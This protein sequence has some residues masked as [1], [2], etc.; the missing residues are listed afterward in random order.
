MLKVWLWFGFKRGQGFLRVNLEFIIM[1]FSSE[2]F[3]TFISPFSLLD[4]F[5]RDFRDFEFSEGKR[6][7]ASDYLFIYLFAGLIP[8]HLLTS[9]LLHVQI[10][11]GPRLKRG[12]IFPSGLSVRLSVTLIWNHNYK[13]VWVQIL[14]CEG[15][16][17]DT[18]AETCTSRCDWADVQHCSTYVPRMIHVCSTYV[19]ALHV[20]S[21]RSCA[22]PSKKR[23]NKNIFPYNHQLILHNKYEFISIGPS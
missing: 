14:Y 1:F 18:H 20:T 11:I 21:I 23:N 19:P 16:V 7:E 4:L 3:T 10:D 17:T 9:N 22:S 2:P 13:H 15:N 6:D 5:L 8:R 12:G